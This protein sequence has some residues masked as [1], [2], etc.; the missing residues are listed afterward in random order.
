VLVDA[1]EI[2][3]AADQIVDAARLRRPMAVAPVAVHPV[4]AA[5]HSRD[6]RAELNRIDLVCADGQPVRWALNLLHRARL[7]RRVYGPELMRLLCARAARQTLP[8]YLYGSWPATVDALRNRSV[9]TIRGS[10]W[11]VPSR[12]GS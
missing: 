6:L 2:D 1:V 10:T 5:L 7:Q 11:W 3:D 12:G 8:V 4:V 9:A